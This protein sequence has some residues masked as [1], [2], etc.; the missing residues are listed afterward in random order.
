M[1]QATNE[2]ERLY[3]NLMDAGCG[4]EATK[5]CMSLARENEWSKLRE[6]LAKHKRD[7]L[8][9]LHTSERQ[10]DCLDYLVYEINRKH[11]IM[12]DRR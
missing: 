9:A 1:A 3:Q 12:L 8:A 5:R 4:E 11:R 6:E 2:E 10:I 7:L